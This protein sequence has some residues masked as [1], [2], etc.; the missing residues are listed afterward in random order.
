MRDAETMPQRRGICHAVGVGRLRS[1]AAKKRSAF[2]ARVGPRRDRRTRLANAGRQRSNAGGRRVLTRI[3]SCNLSGPPN[4][5][6]DG[7]RTGSDKPHPF[8]RDS[9]RCRGP[10]R[11][12]PGAHGLSPGSSPFAPLPPASFSEH[13][14]PLRRDRR[15]TCTSHR[16]HGS[17]WRRL[18]SA[19]DR[20]STRR[21]TCRFRPHNGNPCSTRASCGH[22]VRG[23]RSRR[24]SAGR[25]SV[26]RT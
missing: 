20:I 3:D 2:P 15:R 23:G 19:S 14:P 9:R 13:R 4:T 12:G 24:L 26:R 10:R 1:G 6:G 17:S 11:N 8:R 21:P 7:R 5:S 22:P 18:R 16:P 25:F